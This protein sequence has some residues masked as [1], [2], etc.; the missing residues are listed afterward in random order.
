MAAKTLG[1]PSQLPSAIAMALAAPVGLL[2]YDPNVSISNAHLGIEPD[3]NEDLQLA[4]R[5]RLSLFQ[6]MALSGASYMDCKVVYKDFKLNN[7][8]LEV[9]KIIHKHTSAWVRGAV[10][11]E[12]LKHTAQ[13]NMFSSGDPTVAASLISKLLE[14]TVDKPEETTKVSGTIQIDI[15]DSKL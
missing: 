7:K 6:Q 2:Q 14:G 3:R 4:W 8:H 5:N 12:L 1:A 10:V 13:Q 15:T 9:L 11:E